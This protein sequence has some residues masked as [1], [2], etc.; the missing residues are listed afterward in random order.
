MDDLGRSIYQSYIDSA[1]KLVIQHILLLPRRCP[2]TP[3]QYCWHEFWTSGSVSLEKKRNCGFHNSCQSW[4]WRPDE[5]MTDLLCPY[6]NITNKT[7]GWST[8]PFVEQF[9][10]NCNLFF[11]LL[12]GFFPNKN[13]FFRMALAKRIEP[14]RNLVHMKAFQYFTWYDMRSFFLKDQNIGMSWCKRNIKTLLYSSFS[15]RSK[16]LQSHTWKKG[17]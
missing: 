8:T 9:W 14:N 5:C 12:T 7:N 16:M 10:L 4:S 1:L 13:G 11:C 15:R 3:L 2:T 17:L 6:F